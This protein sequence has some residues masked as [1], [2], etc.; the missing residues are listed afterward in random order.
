MTGISVAELPGGRG[1][2]F[3]LPV[4]FGEFLDRLG[5]DPVFRQDFVR[6]LRNCPFSAFRWETPPVTRDTLDRPFEF[7]LLDA[8]GL[9]RRPDSEAFSEHFTSEP[10]V[11]FPNLGRNAIL[12]VPCPQGPADSYGHLAAFVRHA[13]ESQV[14][15]LWQRVAEEMHQRINSRPVWL[16]TAGGGVSWLHVRLDDEPKYFNHKPYRTGHFSRREER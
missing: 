13:P 3:C 9:A 2:G 16:S 7:V 11:S 4:S 1:L 8:P 6:I 5:A 15:A 10:V 14:D 12:V